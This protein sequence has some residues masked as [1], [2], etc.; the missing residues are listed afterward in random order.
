MKRLKFLIA[1]F[2]VLFCALQSSGQYYKY[3]Y[4]ILTNQFDLVFS[5]S[6]GA[7]MF[8]GDIVPSITSTYDIGSYDLRWDSAYIDDVVITNDLILELNGNQD[9]KFTED[10]GNFAAIALQ[11]QTSGFNTALYFFP[12]D[13]DG[14]DNVNFGLFAKGLPTDRTNSEVLYSLYN[15]ASE[16]FRLWVQATGTG[17]VRS[18]VAYTGNNTNQLR[19][20]SDG[21][22]LLN[23]ANLYG[24]DATG[25]DSFNITD[26]GTNTNILSDNPLKFSNYNRHHDIDVGAAVL[27]P[28]AP[29]PTTVGTFRGL[30]FD[31][32]AEVINFVNEVP[33]EWDGISDMTLEIHWYPTAGDIVANGETVKWDVT[34]RSIAEGEPVD[35]GTAVTITATFTGGASETDKEHYET[36]LTIDYDDVNQPL[37][38][39]D[40][41]GF[42]FDRDV[43]G[44]TY[45]GAGIVFK[46]DL[47]YTANKMPSH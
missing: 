32:D 17:T 8:N 28:T 29:T 39:G 45:S 12:K 15:A 33:E 6:G 10:A 18:L 41:M 3:K 20:S 46:I 42:Q 2:I 22:I 13:G 7:F 40:D 31:A 11:G 5:S 9:Y 34:Y 35:N 36:T 38:V 47:I 16:E 19:L 27:G 26:D 23:S 44:D 30:G 21:S 24:T 14:T 43:S 37:T 25:N 1:L 4:N